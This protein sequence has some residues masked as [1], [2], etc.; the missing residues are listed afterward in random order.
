MNKI[1][2]ALMLFAG[3]A[4]AGNAID[5]RAS[6]DPDGRVEIS[7]V[8]GLVVVEGWS[9]EEVEVKGELGKEVE[10]LE[11]ERDGNL[12]RIKVILPK[13]TRRTS[14]TELFV[15]VPEASR[16]AVNAVSADIKVEGV[17]GAQRHNVTSGDI[18][19]EVWGEDLQATTVSG[20]LSVAG[21]GE[22][23]LVTLTSVSGDL[24]AAD[25]AGELAAST[26]S[27]D[28]EMRSG[29]LSRARL[30]TTNG[31][32]ELETRLAPDARVFADTINGDV[33]ISLSGPVDAEF[34]IETFN[35]SIDNCFGPDPVRVSKYAPGRELSFTEGDGTARVQIK[36]LNGGIELC[37]D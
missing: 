16:L 19:V 9:R 3:S 31:D 2:L 24:T 29:E 17:R 37:K 11:F 32:I 10:R 4:L 34:E 22:K 7:N 23:G 26:V 14:D 18:E 6:A 13:K 33:E 12:T 27:G 20:D 15:K 35:G 21:H 30:H 28:L 8:A 5:E 36:T 1:C 25:V